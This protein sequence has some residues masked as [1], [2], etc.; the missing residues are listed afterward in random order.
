MQ[1]AITLLGSFEVRVNDA[2]IPPAAWKLRHP[3]ELLQMVALSPGQRVPREQ[4]LDA[5]WPGAEARPASN[6]LYHTLHLL[7]SAFVDVGVPKDDPAVQLNDGVLQLNPT[8]EMAIDVREFR[9]QVDQA[10]RQARGRSLDRAVE[11]YRGELLTGFACPDWLAPHRDACRLDYVWALN[12]LAQVHR[13]AGDAERAIALYQKLLD[14]E[15]ADELAHR[16]LMELFDQTQHPERAV[17]QFSACKRAL[18]R[19]LDVDPSPATAAVLERIVSAAQQRKTEGDSARVVARQRYVAP[20]HAIPMLGRSEDMAALRSWL[21][22]GARL[23][24]I[25]AAAGQGKTRLAHALLE[26]SQDD[27]EDGVAVLPLTLLQAPQQLLAELAAVLGVAHAEQPVLERL[28]LH[29]RKRRMLLLLDR[30]EHLAEAGSVLSKLLASAPGLVIVVTSQVP[31]RLAAERVYRLPSLVDRRSEDA[32]QLFCKVASNI[33]CR[34]EHVDDL[35]LVASICLRLG[36][37]AL[38]IHLAA[39][40]AQVLSLPQ[41]LRELDRPL[42]LLV[43]TLRDVEAEHR[44]LR[45]AITRAHSL[46]GRGSRRLFAL[47]GVFRSTFSTDDAAEVLASFFSRDALRP[48]LADL[49]ERHLISASGE[50]LGALNPPRLVLLDSLAQ[51][52]RDKLQEC[53]ETAALEEAHARHYMRRAADYFARV[54]DGNNKEAVAFFQLDRNNL[55]AALA[56]YRDH[57]APAEHLSAVLNLST[58]ASVSGGATDAASMLQDALDKKHS[59]S[60]EERRLSAWCA[61]RLARTFSWRATRQTDPALRLARQLCATSDDPELRAKIVIHLAKDRLNQGKYRVAAALL[62]RQL[63]RQ[64]GAGNAASLVGAF[65]PLSMAQYGL[66]N[67]RGAVASAEAALHHAR[68]SNKPQ[69]LAYA[70]LTQCEQHTRAGALTAARQSLQELLQLPAGCISLLRRLHLQLLQGCLDTEDA[71][72]GSAEV[73]LRQLLAG[74][75][76]PERE[77]TRVF[78]QVSH[79]LNL[80]EQGR[81][82]DIKVLDSLSLATLPHNLAFSEMTVRLLCGRL[83][84]FAARGEWPRAAQSLRQLIERLKDARH[85]L[86]CAWVLE[87]SALALLHRRAWAECGALAQLSQRMVAGMGIEPTQRQRANW[88]RVENALAE[89]GMAADAAG[90]SWLAGAPGAEHQGVE[91][92]L[93]VLRERVLGWVSGERTCTGADVGCWRGGG[94]DAS[95]VQGLHWN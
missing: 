44:S 7:R 75:A 88:Q 78:V 55:L 61:Y 77:R 91:P 73:T 5:L 22:Q 58:L 21:A 49:L 60:A 33:N 12:R 41:M 18:R 66:G 85:G 38:A 43:T 68:A 86:W 46:L 23:I 80:L 47:I 1:L 2:T 70:L 81:F 92:T 64:Q 89:Q 30:F 71:A 93:T 29:L 15:P 24:T 52:A 14:V 65:G 95:S 62:Q 67:V 56:W 69:L 94:F 53:G 34:I 82:T 20:A 35:A 72:F 51:F 59:A 8:L 87:A 79:E 13:E 48:G 25:N 39:R 76:T 6:R 36:G 11:L 10:R 40:Q 26:H 32:V 54:R 74:M 84:L 31:L 3:R 83:R 37:N 9:E 28:A 50:A 17:Y 16:A 63:A 4:A 57:A 45:Q 19:D 42:E 90:I 27:F